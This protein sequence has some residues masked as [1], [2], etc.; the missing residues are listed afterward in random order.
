MRYE[1]RGSGPTLVLLPAL[2][3]DEGL[4][5]FVAPALE[6]SFRLVFPAV[7]EA[8]SIREAALGVLEI[9]SERGIGG[10]G[11][12]GVS[13]GGYISL[14]F[15]R[16]APE[17][18]RAVALL[19]TTAF[20]DSPERKAKRL[21]TIQLLDEGHFEEV[22]ETYAANA[23]PPGYPNDGPAR[24]RLLEM[25]RSLGPEIFRTESVSILKRGSF[26]DVLRAL[27]VPLLCLAGAQDILTPPEIAARIAGEVPGARFD[28]IPGAGHL[29]PLEQP[30]GVAELLGDFFGAALH[31]REIRPASQVFA[32]GFRPSGENSPR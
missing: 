4:W 17:T 22:L 1:A 29:T 31:S 6:R 26:E 16:L 30:A 12:A 18:V 19:D 5:D 15:L 7:W 10:A 32:S 3:C 21:G 14:E 25:A 2:G 13:M 24:T 23:L 11:I 27:R 9:L 8:G 28:T 20:G